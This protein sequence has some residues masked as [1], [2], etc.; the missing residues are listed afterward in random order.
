MIGWEVVSFAGWH[1]VSY[2]KMTGGFFVTRWQHVSS[3]K[4][5]G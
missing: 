3:D 1:V 4:I 5:V 2:D